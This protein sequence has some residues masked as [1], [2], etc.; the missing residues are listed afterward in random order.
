MLIRS[1][2]PLRISFGGGGTDISPYIEER[3]GVVLSATINRYAY[4]SLDTQEKEAIDIVSLDYNTYAKYDVRKILQY[5]GKLDLVKATIK[6]MNVKDAIRLFLHSDA[7]PGSGLGSSSALTVALVGVFNH[8]K[9]LTLSDYQ[10]AELAYNIERKELGLKGGKQDQ[11]NATFGGFN[12][13][14]FFDKVTI[15]NPIHLKDD[16]LN[17]LQYRLMLCFTGNTRLSAGIIDEQMSQYEQGNK[18]VIRALDQTKE[19]AISMKKALLL[20]K[21]NEF[22]SLL[23]EAWCIKQKFSAKIT[24]AHINELYNTA[25]KNG[26]IGGKL[27]GA[28]GGGYILLLCQ[29]D[30]YHIVADKLE[31]IGG[32][33][34]NFSFD[35]NGLRTWEVNNG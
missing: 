12:F 3:G 31:Q 24:D 32:K 26:A 34:T 9:K 8:W 25:R 1:K 11:Y 30:K 35:Y 7:P 10:I 17:E 22:G 18:D 2:A 33:I 19:V 13:I 28:G 16:L 5:D 20:G 15:V 14:E 23:H 29:F 4:T 6:V 27:L 21:L